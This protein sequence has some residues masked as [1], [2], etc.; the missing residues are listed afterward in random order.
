MKKVR[1]LGKITTD[2]EPLLQELTD[3]KGHDLQIHEV[4]SLVHGWLLA[5]APHS[6]ETYT[7]DGSHPVFYYGHRDQLK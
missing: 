7:E 2:I 3:P 4:L 6:I 1:G 5:H